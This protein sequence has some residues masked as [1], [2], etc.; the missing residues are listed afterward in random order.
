MTYVLRPVVRDASLRD[1]PHHEEEFVSIKSR[2]VFAPLHLFH[3]I[4][5][6]ARRARLEGWAPR[7]PC[8][9]VAEIVA[10]FPLALFCQRAP[11][12]R[13][14]FR[15]RMARSAGV[16]H[17]YQQWKTGNLQWRYRQSRGRLTGRCKIENPVSSTRAMRPMRNRAARTSR[18]IDP[19]CATR[20]ACRLHPISP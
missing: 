4:L 10:L 6:S 17:C 12:G 15:D 3:L 16:F 20:G 8:I 2:S 13:R 1:A 5:R 9:A 14:H 11:R 18:G 19:S 7:D